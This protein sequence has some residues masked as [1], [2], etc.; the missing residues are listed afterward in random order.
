MS[1]EKKQRVILCIREFLKWLN[2]GVTKV[3]LE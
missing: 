3:G 2:V 1:G